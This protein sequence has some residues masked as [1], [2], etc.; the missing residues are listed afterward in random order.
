MEPIT[1]TVVA[2]ILITKVL[3]KSG[4][5][6]GEVLT[7][8]MGQAINKIRQYSP[9][10]A[11]ALESG[12][13]QILNLDQGVLAEIPSDKIFGE[14]LVAFAEENALLRQ[15]LEEIQETANKNPG[16]LAEKIGI[17][18]QKDGRVDIKEFKM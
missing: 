2:T 4:D 11:I 8:K 5:K 12:D 10:T 7:N 14:F 18:V 3:E 1:A 16:Q 9:E 15:N 13:T 6:L 17:L